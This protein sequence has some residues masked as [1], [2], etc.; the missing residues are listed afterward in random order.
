MALEMAPG[1]VH[2]KEIATGLTVAQLEDPHSDRAAWLGLASDAG[3]LAVV[4]HYARAVHVWDLRA[5]RRRLKTMNLDWDWPE[6]PAS[7]K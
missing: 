6:F 5:I 2:L 3:R 7:S 1:V 4:A